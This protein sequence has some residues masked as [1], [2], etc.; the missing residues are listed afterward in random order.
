MPDLYFELGRFTNLSSSSQ[1]NTIVGEAAEKKEKPL[2]VVDKRLDEWEEKRPSKVAM[3]E[4]VKING[5]VPRVTWTLVGITA[6]IWRNTG[7]KTCPYCEAMSGKVV[8]VQEKFLPAGVDFNLPG[9]DESLKIRG[10]K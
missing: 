10:P 1:L 9:A 7:R 3:E 6:F 4:N 8:G 2:D 5:S